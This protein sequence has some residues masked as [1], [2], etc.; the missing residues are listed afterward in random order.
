MSYEKTKSK[1]DKIYLLHE[2]PGV[3][4]IPLEIRYFLPSS[5]RA[6]TSFW[7]SLVP[8]PIVQSFT[9]R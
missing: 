6:I 2:Y 4:C 1:P 5:C 9:S 3:G 7:I 8:S